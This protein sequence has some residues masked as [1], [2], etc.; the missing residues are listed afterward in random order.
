MK[1]PY[2]KT[3][4]EMAKMRR[5]GLV[6][7]EAHRA[8]ARLVEPGTKTAA[9]DAEVE[10][11]IREHGAEPLFKGVLGKT[12]FP[13]ATCISINSEVVHG[14]PGPRRLAAGDVV[15]IDI[16]VRLD[17]WCADAAVTHP[18]GAVDPRARHLLEVTEDALR[19]AISRVGESPRWSS[20]AQRL[21]AF[22]RAAGLTVIEELVGHG[23]GREMWEEP[24]VP[25]AYAPAAP[26]IELS[27]GLVLAIEPMASLGGEGVVLLS[28]G[29]TI[30]TAD[31]GWSAH[32]E[33][34]VALT[35]E[36]P[37]V[38]TAGPDGEGWAL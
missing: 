16:G 21:E 4:D 17:G 5:A 3:R 14:I 26:D 23:I 31:G 15:G 30:A 37:W 8:A 13:A 6:A 25:N 33:H 32:F 27:T 2:P 29:W 34:T 19:L 20:V 10:R 36:G 35:D 11:V 18:V 24:P 12:P 22:I 1:R 28:D 7:W 38:L 9:I